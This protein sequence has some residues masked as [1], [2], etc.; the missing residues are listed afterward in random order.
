[1]SLLESGVIVETIYL[2][3]SKAFDKVDH[4]I[5]LKKLSLIGI[6]GKMLTWI[7]SFLTS[8]TQKV[9]VNGLLSHPAPVPSGVPQGSMRDPLLFLVVIGDIDSEILSSFVSS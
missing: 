3:F 5:L 2:D 7:K 9:M 8:R 4:T 1:M 6:R